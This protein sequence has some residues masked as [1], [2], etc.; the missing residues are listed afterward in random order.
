MNT[1][2]DKFADIKILKYNLPNFN[3]LSTKQKLYIYH[4]S[5]AALCGRDI[6]F[7]QNNKWNLQV[8]KL[9]EAVYVSF[10]GDRNTDTFANF[11]TYLKQIWFSNGIH[12]HYSTDKLIPKFTKKDF[13]EL[14][15][16]SEYDDV[17]LNELLDVIFNPNRD[18]KRISLDGNGDL[19]CDSAMNYYQNV[20]QKEAEEFYEAKRKNFGNNAPSFGLN[21][22]LCKKNNELIEE[23]WSVKGKYSSAI[24]AIILHLEQAITYAENTQQG[25]VISK[26][27]EFYK[28]GDLSKFDE[29]SIAWINENEGAVDFI[30]GFIEVYGDPLGIKGSWESIV[31]YI[32][33]TATKRTKLLSDN[34]KWFEANSPIADNYKKDEV[35]GITAKVINVAMLGGDCYPATPIGINLPNSEWIREQYGSKSVTIE[36]ITQAYFADSLGN[37]MLEE[38]AANEM[39]INRAR[40]YGELASNL[41]T[42]LHE[43]LGHG[44]GKM[45]LGIKPEDLKNYYSTIEETRADLF[46]LYYIADPKLI[47]IGI[48]ESEETAKAEFDSYIR[49]GLLTQL[50]RI[51]LGKN[52]EESHMRNRQ[53]IAKWVLEKGKK[54]NVIEYLHR[55]GK[56]YVRINDYTELRTLFGKLLKE[57]Q[58]IK[59]EGDFFAAKEIVETYGV[60][61]DKEIHSQILERFRKLNIAP[62]SGFVNPEFSPIVDAYGNI[63]DIDVLEPNSYTEQM[64]HYSSK[65]SFL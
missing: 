18:K 55:K 12:H 34:A 54:D 5:N 16:K 19:I 50:T 22:T 65:Y 13:I 39:E 57:I 53:L 37:G 15:N 38:F 63:V 30:N 40:K 14:L 4:L 62:Y 43:C 6:L 10:R 58:R 11:Q 49:N 8:R 1:L 23:I 31:N 26:L 60:K 46:A 45:K 42:D 47:E 28:T 24:E 9:L 27:I 64:L 32:D 51:E 33:D 36:N 3:K 17:N 48:V 61:I 20:N 7:D 25:L 44:S 59:S 56:I 41:H 21:S 29:Y 2:V 35:K 52:L